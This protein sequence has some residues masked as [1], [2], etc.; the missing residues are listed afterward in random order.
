MLTMPI[1]TQNIYD[2]VVTVETSNEV[3]AEAH[4]EVDNSVLTIEDQIRDY[5]ADAPAMASVAFCESRFRQYDKHG[6][7]LRGVVNSRDV[8]VFQ[9]NE[10]YHL[11]TALK[12]GIDLYTIEGNLEYAR[13]LYET[14]GLRPWKASQPCWG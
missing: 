14:Q 2:Q 8:G 3:V 7:I 5:F 9:I 10:H 13:H 1:T 12:K 11:E 6:N 4:K